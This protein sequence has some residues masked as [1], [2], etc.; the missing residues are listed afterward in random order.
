[1]GDSLEVNGYGI[2][3]AGGVGVLNFRFIS[4]INQPAAQTSMLSCRRL[5]TSITKLN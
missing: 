5:G 4:D 1:M 3:P 2:Q